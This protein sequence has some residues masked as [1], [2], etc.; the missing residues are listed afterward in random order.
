MVTRLHTHMGPF[1]VE[2]RSLFPRKNI[3]LS[4]LTQW[5][6][7]LVRRGSDL[8]NLQ[9]PAIINEVKVIYVPS[10]NRLSK[11]MRDPIIR[12]HN[13]HRWMPSTKRRRN[14]IIWNI[15]GSAPQYKKSW[16]RTSTASIY[17]SCPRIL[18][19]FADIPRYPVQRGPMQPRVRRKHSKGYSTLI[20]LR[21]WWWVPL[22]KWP[23]PILRSKK[24]GP[25]SH[26]YH[27][28]HRQIPVR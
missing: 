17:V 21:W 16:P 13:I 7:H 5:D 14:S 4:L 27:G 2:E 12:E 10:R 20:H 9:A 22:W 26:Q 1:W 24:N 6:K 23:S 18:A 15:N 28:V 25:R 8:E 11:I 19:L 3:I